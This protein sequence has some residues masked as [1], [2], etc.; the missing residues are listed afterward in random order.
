MLLKPPSVYVKDTGT[1]KGRGV[2]ASRAFISGAVV[3]ESP[4]V[5]LRMHRDRMP[6]EFRDRVFHWGIHR[7]GSA[8]S[9]LALGYG[10]L[11]NH[12]NPA[13]M[14]YEVDRLAVTL[15]F[16]AVRDI[17]ADEELT[18]NYSGDAGAATSEDDWWFEEKKI[19]PITG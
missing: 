11:Y 13:S 17:S 14:R 6:E 8:I 1:V 12:D 18:I 10:S 2:F 9:V 5:V 16:I 15:S 7:D 4:V 3:E 19:K